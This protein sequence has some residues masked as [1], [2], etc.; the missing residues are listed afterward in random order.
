MYYEDATAITMAS[1]GLPE[2]PEPADDDDDD[3]NEDENTTVSLVLFRRN[4][5]NIP[6][7]DGFTLADAQE[8]CE[9]EDTHDDDWFV[10]WRR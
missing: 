2:L 1:Y 5:G 10:G 8:Y 4:Q 7:G 3:E 6:L 9:R